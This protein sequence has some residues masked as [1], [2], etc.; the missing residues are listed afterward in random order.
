MQIIITQTKQYNTTASITSQQSHENWIEL[1]FEYNIMEMEHLLW[2]ML[3]MIVT[4]I[5]EF[6]HCNE[7]VIAP[8]FIWILLR[9]DITSIASHLINAALGTVHNRHYYMQWEMIQPC[10]RLNQSSVKQ[11]EDS[12]NCF[13]ISIIVVVAVMFLISDVLC[14]P[15]DAKVAK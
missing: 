12:C 10:N 2:I 11:C 5:H 3:S 4:I 7:K 15:N 13:F 14:I 1:F 9:C 8:F 6:I